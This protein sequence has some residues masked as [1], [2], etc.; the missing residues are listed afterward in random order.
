MISL[1]SVKMGKKSPY[2]YPPYPLHYQPLHNHFTHCPSRWFPCSQQ[3]QPPSHTPG[4]FREAANTRSF[5]LA[6]PLRPYPPKLIFHNSLKITYF[7][8]SLN[9]YFPISIGCL[10]DVIKLLIFQLESGF[11]SLSIDKQKRTV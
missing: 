1:G 8:T 11:L 7:Y 2:K 9:Q 6:R 5:V 4:E 10:S 3:Q